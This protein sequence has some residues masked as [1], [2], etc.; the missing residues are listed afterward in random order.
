MDKKT[1]TINENIAIAIG[2][3]F[4]INNK[5]EDVIDKINNVT[6]EIIELGIMDIQLEHGI[7]N[8][9]MLRPSLIIGNKGLLFQGLIKYVMSQIPEVKQFNIIA[10]QG[11]LNYLYSFKYTN[12]HLKGQ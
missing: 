9:T 8:I 3:Y 10:Y 4:F 2:D 7:A 5:T 11:P 6:K 12:S 1:K